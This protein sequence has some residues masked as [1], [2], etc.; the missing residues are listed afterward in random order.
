MSTTSDR[1]AFLQSK[2]VQHLYVGTRTLN[3][4]TGRSV[5][6]YLVQR[7]PIL[8]SRTISTGGIPG[9]CIRREE[10]KST[11]SRTTT[12][13]GENLLQS[14]FTEQQHGCVF[15]DENVQLRTDTGS[16]CWTT[17]RQ[18][19]HTGTH[20]GGRLLVYCCSRFA[21]AHLRACWKSAH[22]SDTVCGIP[23]SAPGRWSTCNFSSGGSASPPSRRRDD[24]PC[25]SPNL[26]RQ[27]ATRRATVR[28]RWTRSVPTVRFHQMFQMHDLGERGKPCGG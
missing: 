20:N 9:F 2:D 12:P 21:A 4:G 8:G 22:R 23:S 27:A 15:F 25:R 14:G 26:K 11:V 6:L 1:N 13:H 5:S 10:G 24:C 16:R 19:G 3:F 28:Q 18:H 7:R 17:P